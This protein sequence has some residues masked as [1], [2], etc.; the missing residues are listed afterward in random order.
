MIKQLFS[1]LFAIL[2]VS[3]SF[4][5]AEQFSLAF[6]NDPATSIVIGWSGDAG[7]VH[8]GLADFG[9]NYTSYPYTCLLYTSDA[10]D[11]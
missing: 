1:G 5:A 10:A 6:R 2:L 9:T 7:T 11:E 4:A 3:T 8:Y